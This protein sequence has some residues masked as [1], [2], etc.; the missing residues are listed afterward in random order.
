MCN[1]S[2][3][4]SNKLKAERLLIHT[5]HA[6]V[7]QE[8]IFSLQQSKCVSKRSL[9]H[10][11]P[12]LDEDGILRVRGRLKRASIPSHEK[13]PIII[14]KNSHIAV[15]IIRHYH[16]KVQHQGRR[17]TEGGNSFCWILDSKQ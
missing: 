15:L 12:F 4:I 3:T 13:H 5:V 14:P 2:K 7:F 6:E 11:S 17:F 16:D 1:D 9:V 10:L 8:E